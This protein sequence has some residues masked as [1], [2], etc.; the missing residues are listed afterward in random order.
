MLLRIFDML[1]RAMWKAFGHNAFTMAK[2][3]AYSAIL[4]VFPALLV[5]TTLL[6]LIPDTDTTSGEIRSGFAQILPPD[7]MSLIQSYFQVNH[8]RSVRLVWTASFVTLFAAMGVMMSLM[9]GLRRA[10]QLPRGSWGFWKERA[11]AL[12]LVPG[13][14]LPM[15]FATFIVAFGHNI[16]N[17]M[18]DNA[19][20]ELRA[21]V[22]L[23]WRMIRWAIAV[24]TSITVLTV[25]YHFGV[26]HK[27]TW[28]HVLPG[29]VLAT[30][31]WFLATLLYGW[32]VTRFAD[33]SVVYG[34]LGAG[35]ATL[36]W[37]YMVCLSILIGGEFNAQMFPLANLAPVSGQESKVTLHDPQAVQQ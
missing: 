6:A 36:V 35:V 32:Y 10:Y 37:L 2:A 3:A 26:R 15:V 31:T 20:H 28:R 21:Y 24:L 4:S 5:F 13:T 19:D 30:I 18:I 16:E 12:A 9:E 34:S 7:T 1:R 27:R 25:I 22:L 17:W 23:L 33:Y 11:I 8:A 29:A 14:L